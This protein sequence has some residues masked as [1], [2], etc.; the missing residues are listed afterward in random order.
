M[1]QSCQS[2][3]SPFGNI[4]LPATGLCCKSAGNYGTEATFWRKLKRYWTKFPAKAQ[5]AQAML[6][7]RKNEVAAVGGI[8][9]RPKPH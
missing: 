5:L 2:R 3:P 7:R 1:P 4:N 9:I 6:A 8:G